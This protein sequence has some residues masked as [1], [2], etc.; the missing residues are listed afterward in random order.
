MIKKAQPRT[1]IISQNTLQYDD[2]YPCYGLFDQSLDNNN[3]NCAWGEVQTVVYFTDHEI[4]ELVSSTK[5]H[6]F[7]FSENWN[8][9]VFHKI[10]NPELI[11][12]PNKFSL[13][14]I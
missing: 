7:T 6:M 13:S 14:D 5:E 12:L 10:L 2:S 1:L 9:L 4:G 3:N 8:M 11:Q